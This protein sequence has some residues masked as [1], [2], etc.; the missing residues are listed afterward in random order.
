MNKFLRKLLL[1][2][3]LVAFV[4]TS[5]ISYSQLSVNA[6]V[7]P[8]QLAQSLVGGGLT[9]SNIQLNCPIGGYGSFDATSANVG[10]PQGVLLTSGNLASTLGPNDEGGAGIDNFGA[11]DPQLDGLIPGFQTFDACVLEFDVTVI[12]DT[13][14]FNYVFGSEEYLN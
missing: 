3:A 12:S 7:T 2:C 5:N 1:S 14:K 4:F 6:T 10:I 13:L 9:I 11:G 8:T